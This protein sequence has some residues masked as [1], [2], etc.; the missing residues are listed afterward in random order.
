VSLSV[1]QCILQPVSFDP[2]EVYYGILAIVY[3]RSI[4]SILAYSFWVK[5]IR[6]ELMAI[7]KFNILRVI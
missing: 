2:E 5:I 3:Y 4:P 6:D 7:I 1:R